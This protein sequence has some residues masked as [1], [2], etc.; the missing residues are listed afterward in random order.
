MNLNY[1]SLI[2]DVANFPK[3]GII[4]K[5]IFP[6]ME[7]HFCELI[8]D[9]CSVIPQK[10]WEQIECIAGIESRGF[11]LGCAMAQQM[12]KNFIPIRK[13]GKLPPPTVSKEYE[14]EYGF[15]HIEVA[16]S[17]KAKKLLIV[18]DV[19]ATGGTMEAS[20]QLCKDAGHQVVA[21]LVFINLKFLNDSKDI[22]SLVE[23]T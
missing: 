10:E 6:L 13:K 23:Y 19:L 17:N 20:I 4:F 12:N 8:K 16:K 21:K 15:D 5:D 1:K 9:L 3:E 2:R 22:Y 14:L 7:D 11:I 18:D